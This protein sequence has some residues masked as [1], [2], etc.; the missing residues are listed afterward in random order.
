MTFLPIAPCFLSLYCKSSH[1]HIKRVL[2]MCW[3]WIDHKHLYWKQWFY[4]L[5]QCFWMLWKVMLEAFVN[6]QESLSTID[7]NGSYTVC[8]F[9]YMELWIP[10][11]SFLLGVGKGLLGVK[12]EPKQVLVMPYKAWLTP[13]KN[14]KTL[15][16]TKREK[17]MLF[18]LSR[19]GL[20][21]PC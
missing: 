15:L 6:I 8:G 11:H 7:R 18:R 4:G 12:C 3:I 1:M 10:L 13:Q 9:I 14:S 17:Q 21:K 19:Y 20:L 5:C 2:I 16:I